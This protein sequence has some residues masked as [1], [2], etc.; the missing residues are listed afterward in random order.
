MAEVRAL[1]D[2][3]RAHGGSRVVDTLLPGVVGFCVPVFD[4]DGHM[5]VGIVSMG[6]AGSFD[7][8]WGGA[9]EAPMKQAAAQLS[10]DLGHR[11]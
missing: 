9:V 6:P 1:L 2:D 11:G 8:E 10:R 3:V 4:S 5:V 7:P